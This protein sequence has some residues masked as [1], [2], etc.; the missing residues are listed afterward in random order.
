MLFLLFV[1]F[2]SAARR[3]VFSTDV[4]RFFSCY[5]E[6]FGEYRFQS[7]T[8]LINN[9]ESQ[10]FQLFWRKMAP[11]VKTQERRHQIHCILV[12]TY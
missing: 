4:F 5:K 6:H 11:Q 12:Y 10:L 3:H 9:L 7:E 1:L 8:S 2:L